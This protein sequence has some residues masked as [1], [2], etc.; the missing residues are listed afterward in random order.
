MRKILF[1]LMISLVLPA[2]AAKAP[3]QAP[4][5]A[6]L[7]HAG[8]ICRNTGGFGRVFGRGYGQVDATASDDWVPFEKLT[9]EPHAITAEA[10]FR[11][12]G[13]TIEDDV[14]RAEKFLKALDHAVTGTHHFKHRETSGGAVR[15]SDGKAAGSGLVLELHQDREQIIATCTGG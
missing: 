11:G 7:R 4:P 2:A 5:A 15:F 9:I 1:L 13:E 12:T 14:A 8:D 6:V 3:P 10:S